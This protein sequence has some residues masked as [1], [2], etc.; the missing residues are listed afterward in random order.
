VFLVLLFICNDVLSSNPKCV[1]PKKAIVKK[2][3]K[4]PRNFCDGRVMAKILIVLTIQVN[5]LPELSLLNFLPLAY[6]HKHFLA[7][8]LD[9]TF[10]S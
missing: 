7:A 4:S 5:L 8:T 2:D 1:A 9:F 3:V 10:F 6:H